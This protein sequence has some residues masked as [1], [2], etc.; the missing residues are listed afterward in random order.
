MMGTEW[1][2]HDVPRLCDGKEMRN[3][4]KSL[5]KPQLHCED[6]FKR[7]CEGEFQDLLSFK[8]ELAPFL[9]LGMLLE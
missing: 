7:C 9:L 4:Y 1:S 5:C 8:I 3:L 2:C 6:A